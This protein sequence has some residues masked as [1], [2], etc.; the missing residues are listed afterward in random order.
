[1]KRGKRKIRYIWELG[2]EE[3]KAREEG[4]KK[5]REIGGEERESG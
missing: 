5:E 3:G 4:R 2:G 1:M